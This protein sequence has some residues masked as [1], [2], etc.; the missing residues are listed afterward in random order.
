MHVFTILINHFD[1]FFSSPDGV[2][3]WTGISLGWTVSNTITLIITIPIP[4]LHSEIN[5]PFHSIWF[6][7][8]DPPH[9]TAMNIVLYGSTVLIG[10]GGSTL[11]VTSLSMVAD[12]IGCA[13]VSY[14]SMS[15]FVIT[16]V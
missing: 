14:K 1:F 5:F 10:A 9:S 15:T 13:V 6:W 4:N 11:L 12:L 16:A 2:L 3:H 7:M 8:Q